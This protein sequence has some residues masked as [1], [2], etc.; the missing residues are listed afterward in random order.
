MSTANRP[1]LLGALITLGVVLAFAGT[2]ALVALNVPVQ[3][4]TGG[5]CDRTQQVQDAILAQ[6]PSI[7]DCANVTD[8]HLRYVVILLAWRILVLPS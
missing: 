3:A 8:T 2:A 1:G 6:L 5:I 4:S 7:S